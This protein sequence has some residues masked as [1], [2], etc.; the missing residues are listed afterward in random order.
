LPL[1]DLAANTTTNVDHGKAAKLTMV[2]KGGYSVFAEIQH[3][4]KTVY[5]RKTTV[6][7]LLQE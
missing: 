2:N 1:F 5:V 3:G 7:W 6:V 4:G